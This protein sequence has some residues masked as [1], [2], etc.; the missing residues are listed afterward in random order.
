MAEVMS[1]IQLYELGPTRSARVRWTLLEAGLAYESLGNDIEVFRSAELRRVHPLGKLPAAVIDG[2][3][4]FESA[5]IVTAIADLVPEKELV[6]RPGTWERN[7]HYQW[8]SFVLTEME[9]YV[10]SS[11]INTIDFVLPAE[12]RVPEIVEQNSRMY[13][14]AA[15]V[16]D[17]VLAASDSGYLVGER[18]SV[19]DVI[20]GYTVSWGQEQGMLD[21]CPAL[22][23]YLRR[24]MQREHCPLVWH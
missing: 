22:V 1:R 6:A 5:A 10:H 4:L 3:P 18:F 14:R 24:L 12:E 20:A 9:P 13:R 2:R 19:T 8:T 21:A 16:L 11:E 15:A 23:A 17:A 7:L